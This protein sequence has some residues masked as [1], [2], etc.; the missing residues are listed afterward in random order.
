MEKCDYFGN[1]A[2]HYAVRS[3][4]IKCVKFLINF[5]P[6]LIW[7][8]DINNLNAKELAEILEYKEMLNVL[9]EFLKDQDTSKYFK[10][11]I[12]EYKRAQKRRDKY[13]ILMKNAAKSQ[14]NEYRKKKLFLFRFGSKDYLAFD[15][16]VFDD[17]VVLSSSSPSLGQSASYECAKN[18]CI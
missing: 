13:S 12:T 9:N 18:S 1:S 7:M 14:L 3:R 11:Q 4:S 16:I 10:F 8:M 15:R 2:L 17:N 5:E 6:K